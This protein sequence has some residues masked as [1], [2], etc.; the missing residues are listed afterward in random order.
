MKLKKPAKA[1]RVKEMQFS[2]RTEPHDYETKLRKLR[3]F[4]ELKHDVKISVV[5]K[6]AKTYGVYNEE[7]GMVV[8][9]T[10]GDGLWSEFG[11]GDGDLVLW[12]GYSMTAMDW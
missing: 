5:A 3:K 1:K 9:L 12:L 11:D 10:I 4:L 8:L 7:F 2:S 6:R